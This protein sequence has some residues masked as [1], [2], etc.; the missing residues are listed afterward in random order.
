MT[1]PSENHANELAH[2]GEKWREM[3]RLAGELERIAIHNRETLYD[4]ERDVL[5]EVAARLRDISAR[6]ERAQKAW[7]VVRAM[8]DHHHYRGSIPPPV[9]DV[10]EAKRREV[11]E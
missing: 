9:D 11:Q 4:N 2:S 10:E 7:G 5:N 6:E 1:N 3:A 8:L